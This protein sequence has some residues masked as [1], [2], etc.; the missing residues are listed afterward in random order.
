MVILDET[1][2]HTHRPVFRE[3]LPG[4]QGHLHR[5]ALFLITAHHSFIA[6]VHW[7]HT[8]GSSVPTPEYLE[9]RAVHMR[10]Q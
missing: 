2:A 8:S 7:R 1:S 6:R 9:Y 5:S 4:S 3:P 10:P